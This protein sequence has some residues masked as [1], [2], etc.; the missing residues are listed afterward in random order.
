MEIKEIDIS[1]ISSI[2]P[3]YISYYNEQENSCWT[4]A[5]VKKRIYQVLTTQDSYGLIMKDKDITIGFVMGYFKQYDDIRS[6]FLE[7]ILIATEYQNKGY[8]SA[9]LKEIETRVINKG[10]SC[11]EMQ[12]VSDELHEHY[13]GKAGYR[14][15]K[16]FVMKVK[17]FE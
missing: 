11:I 14:N 4:E 6:Y 2:I 15:A 17:W 8:G 10:A 13:Y 9:L 1:D 5:T 3:A 16:N 7:E 12:A